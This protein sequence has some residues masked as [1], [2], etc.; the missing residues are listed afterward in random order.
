MNISRS[1][2][3]R[4]FESKVVEKMKTLILFS[5]TFLKNLAVYDI[6]AMW[7]KHGTAGQTTDD[8]IVHAHCMLDKY[9][10]TH[11]HSECVIL[12]AFHNNN[13]ARTRLSVTVIVHCLS[14]S[15]I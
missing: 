12:T 15:K 6:R 4:V 3:L 13:V 5:I 7:T 2:I 8:N 1:N 10:Y 9:G 14:C 11:T